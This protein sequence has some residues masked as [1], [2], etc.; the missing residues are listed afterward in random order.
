[1]SSGVRSGKGDNRTRDGRQ[2]DEDSASIGKA[3]STEGVS[4]HEP[5]PGNTVL[6]R[7]FVWFLNRHDGW[8]RIVPEDDA[9]ACYLKWKMNTGRWPNHYVM[10]R[11]Q[12]WQIEYGLALLQS[13]LEEVDLGVRRP[14]QD[15]PYT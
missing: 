14:T 15:H 6:F 11:C 10:V 4:P 2:S 12:S 9:Q 3:L 5:R 7:V 8:L 1:M 13:K